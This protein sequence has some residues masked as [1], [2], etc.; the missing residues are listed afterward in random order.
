MKTRLK[1]WAARDNSA[2]VS[3]HFEPLCRALTLRGNFNQAAARAQ[4]P[5]GKKRSGGGGMFN[6]SRRPF[7]TVLVTGAKT[8]ST[9]AYNPPVNERC[10]RD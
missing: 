7:M 6:I 5:D 8:D 1:P 10:L 9:R 4:K 2:G 3:G